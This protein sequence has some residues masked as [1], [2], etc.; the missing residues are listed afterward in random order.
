MTNL[1]THIHQHL[2]LRGL[3]NLVRQ[4]ERVLRNNQY[5]HHVRRWLTQ[6]RGPSFSYLLC[7]VYLL[8]ART[9][10]VAQ[11]FHRSQATE[12]LWRP[13]HSGD[14]SHSKHHSRRH[15]HCRN[16]PITNIKMYQVH[17]LLQYM[18]R[19]YR[20]PFLN[21]SEISKSSFTG[22]A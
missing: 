4:V 12:I 21:A 11:S 6:L 5:N 9:L 20:V 13:L 2:L 17:R 8:N 18:N 7:L 10:G 14:K 22:T 19:D 15:Q 3:C 16:G 1:I